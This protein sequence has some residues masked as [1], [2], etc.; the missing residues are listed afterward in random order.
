MRRHNVMV[1]LLPSL[2]P[3]S[4]GLTNYQTKWACQPQ[5]CFRTT[6]QMRVSLRCDMAG[7]PAEEGES[8]LTVNRPKCQRKIENGTGPH[9]HCRRDQTAYPFLPQDRK[10]TRL[11]SSHVE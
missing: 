11:N 4:P 1:T 2:C 10:S 5:I 3:E 9:T 6:T 8:I 7:L